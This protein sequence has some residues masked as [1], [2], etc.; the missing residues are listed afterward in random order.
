[1]TDTMGKYVT[2]DRATISDKANVTISDDGKS[3]TWNLT[4]VEP[5]VNEETGTKTY[6]L[7]Y[8]V[9]LNTEQEGFENG[10]AYATNGDA[11]FTYTIK[12]TSSTI[13]IP[14]A[15]SPS[16]SGGPV[17]KTI[18]V[19]FVDK[20]NK[21]VDT[22]EMTVDAS[23]TEIALDD[24]KLPT[25]AEPKFLRLTDDQPESLTIQDGQVTVYVER[26]VGVNYHLT[27]TDEYKEGEVN[28]AINATEVDTSTLTDIP[29]GYELVTPGN[30]KI[31]D[32][33]ISV[34]VQPVATVQ[35]V[36][37]NFVAEGNE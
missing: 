34:D 33:W 1:M 36:V 9:T 17:T 12:D 21:E 26:Y 7:T 23:A 11:S 14:G 15:D 8:Q 6:T 24:I 18:T 31:Y 19:K 22:D 4:N 37:V 27:D 3:F 16:V 20:D 30:V 13:T 28:V 35:T 10:T 2:L 25:D 32:G 5:V 29:S